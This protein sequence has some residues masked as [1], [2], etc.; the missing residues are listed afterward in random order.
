MISGVENGELTEPLPF[1]RC[2]RLSHIFCLCSLDWKPNWIE[3]CVL[4]I[5]YLGDEDNFQI[6]HGGFGVFQKSMCDSDACVGT[7]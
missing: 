5:S 1:S 4:T 6:L 2:S 7:S 3:Q